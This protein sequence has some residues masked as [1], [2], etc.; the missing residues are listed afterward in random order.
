MNGVHDDPLAWSD[1]EI[2]AEELAEAELAEHFHHGAIGS[3]AESGR[4]LSRRRALGV[5][6]EFRMKHEPNANA[7]EVAAAVNEAHTADRKASK[8]YR[9][10]RSL[11]TKAQQK[12][13]LAVFEAA[14]AELDAMTKTKRKALRKGLSP[15]SRAIQ[16]RVALH[17]SL[18]APAEYIDGEDIADRSVKW[19]KRFNYYGDDHGANIDALWLILAN[20]F[21][22]LGVMMP[23]LHICAP[24]YGT[25]KTNHGEYVGLL[26]PDYMMAASFS[27]SS[28]VRYQEAKPASVMVLDEVDAYWVGGQSSSDSTES[29]RAVID[30]AC[31]P[32]GGFIRSE[33]DGESGEWI[34]RE[35]RVYAACV[36]IGRGDLP[37]S[38]ATRAI[39]QHQKKKLPGE[40]VERF[41]LREQEPAVNEL[42]TSI[43]QWALANVGAIERRLGRDLPNELENRD[44]QKWEGI[45]AVADVLGGGWPERARAAA[46]ADVTSVSRRPRSTS[47][48]LLG[49]VRTAFGDSD[50]ITA[51]ELLNRLRMM[52]ESPWGEWDHGQPLDTRMM[53]R[54]LKDYGIPSNYSLRFPDHQTPQRGWRRGDWAETWSRYLSPETPALPTL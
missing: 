24:E 34:P 30:T 44:A 1:E 35:I 38:I 22:P 47:N 4:H 14:K 10:G 7:G 31:Y 20:V 27:P 26:A 36:L 41:R 42:R 40:V 28:F 18:Q 16:R 51:S 15:E 33:R 12:A 37:E 29:M 53:M 11:P 17:N 21:R 45:I 43:T 8:A 3:L 39:K 46:I 6:E 48:M 19:L 50:R 2:D 32:T 25:G 23:F 13:N 52:E 49:D 54:L 9:R 5:A